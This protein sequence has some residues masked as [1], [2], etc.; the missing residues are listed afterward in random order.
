[1]SGINKNALFYAVS[2]GI[3]IYI[4]TGL[5]VNLIFSAIRLLQGPSAAML[6]RQLLQWVAEFAPAFFVGYILVKTAPED[7]NAVN[8]ASAGL[9]FSSLLFLYNTA[10]M[11]VLAKGHGVSWF[12]I[13]LGISVVPVQIA[14]A[15]IGGVAASRR[16]SES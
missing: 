2:M 5:G 8:S 6:F 16:I 4:I 12:I 9:V 11:L 1:M 15:V 14:V 13:A 7:N 10:M 3:V